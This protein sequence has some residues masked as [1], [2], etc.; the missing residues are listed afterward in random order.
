MVGFA[1]RENVRSTLGF[2]ESMRPFGATVRQRRIHTSGTDTRYKMIQ[3]WW[4]V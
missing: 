4:D 2:L 3:Y 1:G